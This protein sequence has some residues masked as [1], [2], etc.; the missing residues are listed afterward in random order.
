MSVFAPTIISLAVSYATLC[1]LYGTERNAP[2]WLNW[3]L[4][5]W[6]RI[7]HDW[8]RPKPAPISP[9]YT[10]TAVLEHDLLGVQ[11][12][13]GTAAALAVG[14]RSAG[15]CLNHRPIATVTSGAPISSGTWAGC[16]RGMTLNDNG[17]WEIA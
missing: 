9:N 12:Q 15:H 8:R 11:P 13:P 5:I 17:I 16:G 1:G 6:N 3:P 2:R 10:A 7:A 14:V 4:P